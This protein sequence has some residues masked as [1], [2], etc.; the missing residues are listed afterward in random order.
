MK[1]YSLS[2]GDVSYVRALDMLYAV[3]NDGDLA[4]CDELEDLAPGITVMKTGGELSGVEI[5]DFEK[6]YGEPPLSLLVESTI[7]EP[8]ILEIPFALA[9]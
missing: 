3:Y 9:E 2:H 4:C 8:F 7:I 5:Y 6:T 1:T